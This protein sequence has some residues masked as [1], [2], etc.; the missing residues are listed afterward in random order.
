MRRS[1][2]GSCVSTE[3]ASQ[4]AEHAMVTREQADVLYSEIERLPGAFRASLV[5]CYFEG[6]SPDEAARRLR[7]PA[8]TVR[9]RL[10][11]ACDKLRRALARRGVAISSVTLIAMLSSRSTSA[12]S[13][14]SPLCQSTT[15]AAM[16]FAAGQAAAGLASAS[17]MALAQEVLRSML[18]SQLRVVALSVLLLGAMAT[19]AGY[20]NYSFA[21]KEEPVRNPGG[22]ANGLASAPRSPAADHSRPAPKP[23]S[24]NPGRMLVTGNVLDPEG[25]PIKGAVVDLVARPRTAWVGAS[26]SNDSLLLLGQ[27]STDDAGRFRLESLR[28][29]SSRFLEVH[30]LAAAPGFGIGWATLDAS[31]EKPEARIRLEPEQVVVVKLVDVTGRPAAGVDVGVKGM[32]RPTGPGESDGVTVRD[33]PD[34]ELRVWPGTLKTDSQGKIRLTG[35]GRGLTVSLLIQDMRYARQD[36]YINTD[37]AASSKDVTIALEPGANHRRARPCRR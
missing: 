19:G 18:L 20:W 15:T 14:S 8:G 1:G 31:A 9:S 27:G 5:L 32:W 13:I 26:E 10:A 4:P 29:N 16:K 12:A 35:I 37:G 17:A 23:S 36:H 34:K 2:S 7:C 28:T 33:H 25:K 22:D 11:R 30:A 24:P 3:P 21:T 6:L